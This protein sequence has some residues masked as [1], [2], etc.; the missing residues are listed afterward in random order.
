MTFIPEKPQ[1]LI[2]VLP[3][4][5]MHAFD[6]ENSEVPIWALDLNARIPKPFFTTSDPVVGVAFEPAPSSPPLTNGDLA[7]GDATQAHSEGVPSS[8][9]AAVFWGS[10][11][12]CKLR[13]DW[14]GQ[15]TGRRK[16]RKSRAQRPLPSNSDVQTSTGEARD[17][18][19]ITH[20]RSILALDFLK[21]GE[22]LMVERPLIDMLSKLP[23][24]FFKPKYGR[25]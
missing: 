23:P 1:I 8:Q 4:N 5:T 19:I 20:Y 2:L 7:M 24:A 22:L 21:T 15:H 14:I 11:W 9:P 18:R 6:V 10:T 3:N 12:L 13:L 17:V 16:R 25:T